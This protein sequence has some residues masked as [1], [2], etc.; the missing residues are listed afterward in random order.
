[1]P[2]EA[3]VIFPRAKKAGPRRMGLR[4]CAGTTSVVRL[5]RRRSDQSQTV[6]PVVPICRGHSCLLIDPE[7]LHA[8][9]RPAL[10]TR[11][12]SR[13]SRTLGAGCDGRGH[14]ER[15]TIMA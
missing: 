14:V 1:M 3:N 9:H 7:T 5:D 2:I 6:L 4:A 15:R 10:F 13:S 11:G 12:V 8:S